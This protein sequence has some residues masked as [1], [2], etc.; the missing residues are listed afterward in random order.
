MITGNQSEI[1]IYV[2][3]QNGTRLVRKYVIPGQLGPHELLI[4]NQ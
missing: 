2:K 3:L 1:E 4:R